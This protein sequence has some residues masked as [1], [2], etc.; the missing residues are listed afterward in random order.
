M[1]ALRGG[2]RDAMPEGRTP[3][4]RLRVV[5]ARQVLWVLYVDWMGLRVERGRHRET[6][7]G[8]IRGGKGAGSNGGITIQIKSKSKSKIRIKIRSRIRI[9]SRSRRGKREGNP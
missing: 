1:D 2:I 7:T 3:G 4:P 9:R 5:S 6:V 8:P